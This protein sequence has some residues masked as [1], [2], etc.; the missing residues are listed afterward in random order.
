V[1]G[2]STAGGT[3][4]TWRTSVKDTTVTA[5]ALAGQ[6][7][8]LLVGWRTLKQLVLALPAQP[9]LARFSPPG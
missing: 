2:S 6:A 7:F 3:N 1:F 5:A 4:S 8:L 9:T